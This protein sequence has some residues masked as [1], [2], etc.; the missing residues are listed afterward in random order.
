[1][2]SVLIATLNLDKKLTT[3]VKSILACPF[4]RYEIIIIH[5]TKRRKIRK[6]PFILRNSHVRLIH[7]NTFGKSRALNL[8]IQIAR[9]KYC[10]I[11]DDDCIVSDTWLSSIQDFFKTSS[12]DGVFGTTLPYK[13]NIHQGLHCPSV[14]EN[15]SKF[16]T[17]NP[18]TIV[19]E[20]LGVGN[21]LCVRKDVLLR[22]GGFT[23]WL[24]PGNGTVGGG[25]ENELVYRLL[26]QGYSISHDPSIKVFHNKWLGYWQYQIQQSR[27]SEGIIAYCTFHYFHSKDKQIISIAKH[28]ITHRLFS[29][30]SHVASQWTRYPL[31][32]RQ[33]HIREL[34]STI[35]EFLALISGFIKGGYHAYINK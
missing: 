30:F 13:Q 20:E 29:M 22:I 15:I 2:I 6:I 21:N 18:Y 9:G 34:V 19:Q 31:K 16:T 1:M 5:Q 27:Y 4:Y 32:P 8:A 3:C 26:R 17:R 23:P 14:N 12:A 33:W 11:T 7:T 10:A 28:H 25:D 24:G 35:P